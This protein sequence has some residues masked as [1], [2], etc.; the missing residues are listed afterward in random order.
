MA[1]LLDSKSAF[2]SVDRQALWQ[3][4]ALKGVP[5]KFLSLLKALYTNTRGRV[6][7]CGHQAKSDTDADSPFL[8]N[9]VIDL[10]TE[11]SLSIS[12]TREVELLPSCPLVDIEYADDIALLGSDPSETQAI[13]N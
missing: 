6:R 13:L 4:L 9:F 1:V 8:F 5:F 12:D 2:D 3:C 10:P 7:L 11:S